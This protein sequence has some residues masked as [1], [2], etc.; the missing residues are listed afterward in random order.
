MEYKKD[1]DSITIKW[2]TNHNAESEIRYGDNQELEQKKKDEEKEKDHKMKIK[3][4]EPDTWYYFRIKCTD[5]NDDTDRSRVYKVKTKAS[6]TLWNSLIP[7]QWQEADNIEANYEKVEIKV[8]DKE[9]VKE[10]TNEEYQP[11]F[12]Q[13]LEEESIPKKP[14]IISRTFSKTK[15]AILSPFNIIYAGVLSIKDKITELPEQLTILWTNLTQ[16]KEKQYFT[17]Q[18]SKK[19]NKKIFKEIK[20]QLLNNKLK[21]LA[22]TEATLS[23]EPQTSISDQNG[24]VAFKEVEAGTHTLAFAHADEQLN[25]E[26]VIDEPATEEGIIRA[27]IVP[28]KAGEQNTILFLL[29]IIAITALPI[30]FLL[31]TFIGKKKGRQKTQDNS[32]KI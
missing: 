10:G 20:F 25:K 16:K 12:G 29:G 13:D 18:V 21:P 2:E 17:T 19:E 5:N 26:V 1:D 14:G 15:Q 23:S 6:E 24:I 22:F 9:E 32:A 7:S 28:I 27:E 4:L 3:N 31:G 30:F 11:E 8:S